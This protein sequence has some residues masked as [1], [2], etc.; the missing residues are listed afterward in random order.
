MFGGIQKMNFYD[1]CYKYVFNNDKIN[2][3]LLEPIE[4]MNI[5]LVIV[6]FSIIFKIKKDKKYMIKT[7]LMMEA[8]YVIN[9]I[10][11]NQI[12]S[13]FLLVIESVALIK[14]FTE[15]DLSKS[16]FYLIIPLPW[17]SD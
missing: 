17:F 11:L 3:I 5:V 7:M 9:R 13:Q 4:F 16:F 8:I 15:E 2:T 10:F 1:F 14:K 12:I 6:L